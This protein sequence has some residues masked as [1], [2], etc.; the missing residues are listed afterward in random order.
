MLR[1]EFLDPMRLS[2]A[3]AARAMGMPFQRLNAVVQG[4]RSVTPSTALRLA[5]YLGTTPELWLNLQRNV[6]LYHAIREEG[7]AL[8]SIVPVEH[9]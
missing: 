5:R 4:R 1:A 2:Q 7:A 9:K 3:E 6:D 8:E